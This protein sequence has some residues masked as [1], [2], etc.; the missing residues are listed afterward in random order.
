M[1]AVGG[2][3]VGQG[4]GSVSMYVHVTGMWLDPSKISSQEQMYYDLLVSLFSQLTFLVDSQPP[5]KGS[6]SGRLLL[7]SFFKVRSP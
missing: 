7:Q 1:C 2:A 4:K 3:G 5:A 6:T